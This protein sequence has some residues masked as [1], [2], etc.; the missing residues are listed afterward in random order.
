MMT[1]FAFENRDMF[2]NNF[3]ELRI[4]IRIWFKQSISATNLS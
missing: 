3:E 2:K 1:D 4:R